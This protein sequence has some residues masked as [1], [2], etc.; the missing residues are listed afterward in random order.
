MAR[1]LKI[2]QALPECRDMS[3]APELRGPWGNAAFK[4]NQDNFSVSVVLMLTVL[5]PGSDSSGISFQEF[6]RYCQR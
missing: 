3:L 5:C 6:H 4:L 2:I 1:R